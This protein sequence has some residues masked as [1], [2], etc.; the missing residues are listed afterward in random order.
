LLLPGGKLRNARVRIERDG[1]LR[2]ETADAVFQ[3]VS[4]G[5]RR[6]IRGVNAALFTELE[7]RFVREPDGTWLEVHAEVCQY[8]TEMD[9]WSR[10]TPKRRHST[11]R[12]N[13]GSVVTCTLER[14]RSVIHDQ[15]RL[16][17]STS[18]T[19][20]DRTRIEEQEMLLRRGNGERFAAWRREYDSR[21]RQNKVL[22]YQYPRRICGTYRHVRDKIESWESDAQRWLAGPDGNFLGGTQPLMH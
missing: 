1:A 9:F 21:Y 15:E 19:N 13:D 11:T 17:R 7:S 18:I 6:L 5:D 3:F 14:E 10:N 12:M 4:A 20:P 8:R 22:E 2:I 16:T